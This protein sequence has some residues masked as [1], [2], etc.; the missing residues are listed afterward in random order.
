MRNNVN[1]PQAHSPAWVAQTW[2]SFAISVGVTTLGIW[3]LPDNGWIKGFLAMGLLFSVAS[4]FSLAKTVRDLHEAERLAARV[5]EA[6]LNKLITE[7]DPLA[8]PA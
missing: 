4:T 7:H 6:R 3:F 8:P 1:V 5:D 2:L